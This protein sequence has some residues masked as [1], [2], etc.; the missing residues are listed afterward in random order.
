VASPGCRFIVADFS[1]IEARVIAWLAGEKWRLEVFATHGKI[2]EASGAAM[3]KVP[4]EAVTKTSDIRA[5]AKIA[6]L[7]LGFQGGVNALLKMDSKKEL[8]PDEL[9]EIVEKWRAA[10]PAI[11]KMWYAIQNCAIKAVQR[12]GTSIEYVIPGTPGKGIHTVT[13]M[14]EKGIMFIKLPSGRR[15]AYIRPRLKEGK[16]GKPVLEY[17]GMDQTTKKWC[18]QQTYGGKLVENIVQGTARD[19]LADKIVDSI[20]SGYCIALHV[21]DEIVADMPHGQG[22]LKE[23]C[24]IMSVPV[25]WA[26]GLPLAAD[27]FETAYYRKD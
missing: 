17:E 3:F 7:A 5:K 18:R 11:V 15:L 20:D 4:I 1:A 22:S 14:V 10:S 27:G 16:F 13:F 23:M 2:Y 8:N 24:D 6:E 25:S 19:L 9:P 21:H 12:P 26:P